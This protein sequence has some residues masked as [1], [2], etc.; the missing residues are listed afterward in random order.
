MRHVAIPENPGEL[1][2]DENRC[3]E[4]RPIISSRKLAAIM[5]TLSMVRM[6]VP[7]VSVGLC[8]MRINRHGAERGMARTS[9]GAMGR[10]RHAPVA[11]DVPACS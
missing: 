2:H 9:R 4:H 3:E 8:R 5:R 10:R 1:D 7:P 6:R 11:N